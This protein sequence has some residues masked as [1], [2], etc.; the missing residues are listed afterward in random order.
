MFATSGMDCFDYLIGDSHVVA[1]GEEPFYTERVVPLPGC[2][3]AFEVTYPVPE[4][5]PLVWALRMRSKYC[6]G[7]S[8]E[9][10]P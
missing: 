3:L 8:P 2:Y 4:V 6:R 10:V 7:G 1:A 9:Q 5:T